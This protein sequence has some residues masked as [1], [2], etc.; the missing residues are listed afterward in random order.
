MKSLSKSKNLSI[1]M[2]ALG[3]FGFYVPYG[4]MTKALSKGLFSETG[5]VISGF[6]MLPSVVIATFITLAIIAHYT[7]WDKFAGHKTIFGKNIPFSTNKWTLFSGIATAFIIMT[8]TLAY[9]FVGISIV[10][11]ALL[12][13]GGV[14]L[15]A[16]LVDLGYRRKVNWYSIAALILSL[17]ALLLIFSDKGGYTLTMIAGLNIGFYLLGYVFRLQ[18]MTKIAKDGDKETNY[19]FFAEEMYIAMYT[20]VLLPLL[21]AII[22]FG[23]IGQD[24]YLGFV[25][26]TMTPLVIPAFIIGSLYACL[27]VFGSRIYLNYRENTFCIPINR[28][29]SLLAGVV[30]SLVLGWITGESFVNGIQLLS[31]VILIL[32]TLF[33]AYPALA[34]RFGWN[35]IVGIANE[36]KAYLFVCPGNTGRSPMAEK[37]CRKRIRDILSRENIQSN[38]IQVSS[39]G[40]DPKIGM[41]LSNGA[42][43]ALEEFDVLS[44]EHTSKKLTL[45]MIRK[46]NVI[47]CITETHKKNII[48]KFPAA[49][50][51]IV[52]MDPENT[53]PVPHSQDVNTYKLCAKMLDSMIENAL[54]T[55]LI[56]I[57]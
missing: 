23:S 10:F 6:Q 14:L 11:A 38:T 18:F 49:T 33:L 42:K 37:I 34:N 22:G 50:L 30:A 19:R 41:P 46:A 40:I 36:N 39:A 57:A 53:L 25:E 32:A 35:N 51:K 28:C 1:W 27:Y 47:F 8:T 5:T 15:M 4:A 7:G 54:E 17:F 26:F 44:L 43:K 13:R 21:L 52:C 29:S 24:L 55:K 45:E 31:S 12:M 48:K 56:K 20:I 9:S 3:Y 2:L 16:P